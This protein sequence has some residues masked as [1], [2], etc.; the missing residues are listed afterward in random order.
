MKFNYPYIIS[1]LQLLMFLFWLMWKRCY[2]LWC[3]LFR[4]STLFLE[5]CESD[6]MT[7]RKL[8]VLCYSFSRNSTICDIERTIRSSRRQ[9]K[10]RPIL[11]NSIRT[12][13]RKEKHNEKNLRSEQFT[14][15]KLSWR[16]VENMAKSSLNIHP[17][18]SIE[19]W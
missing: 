8:T 4:T 19:L 10:W 13:E 17:T 2:I 11:F 3:S 12:K 14:T 7:N 6:V 9:G 16:L 18:P 5:V 1:L 15:S